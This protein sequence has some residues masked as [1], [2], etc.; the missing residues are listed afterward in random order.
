MEMFNTMRDLYFNEH[1]LSNKLIEKVK[2]SDTFKE[3]VAIYNN[4]ETIT[5][6][7]LELVRKLLKE[8][9]DLYALFLKINCFLYRYDSSK[10]NNKLQKYS[11]HIFNGVEFTI[12]ID[13]V[14][15]ITYF[16]L[17][18]K[19]I[20]KLFIK[21]IIN[22]RLRPHNE[23]VILRKILNRQPQD[24]LLTYLYSKTDDL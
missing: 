15:I 12:T 2:D 13:D 23:I 3:F 17:R 9:F 11:K 21:F 19:F 4:K 7:M 24:E 10:L 14:A 8:E 22:N 20:I 1:I 6:D 5:K 18:H 16:Y